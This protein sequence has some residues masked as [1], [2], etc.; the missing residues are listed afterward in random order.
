M[1]VS[2]RWWIARRRAPVRAGWS[3]TAAAR[4]PTERGRRARWA[5]IACRRREGVPQLPPRM[6][7]SGSTSAISAATTPE[8][9]RAS[10]WRTA[11]WSSRTRR[12]RPTSMAVDARS[13]QAQLG[14]DLGER[15]GPAVRAG[16]DEVGDLA[17]E[18][19]VPA[20]HLAVADDCAAQALA[21]VEV[22]E[23]VEGAVAGFAFG[24]GGPVH[25]VVDY[26]RPVDERREDVG[27]GELADQ[28]RRVG[29]VDE[30]PGGAVDGIG[31]ADHGEPDRGPASA[32]TDGRG[33]QGRGDRAPGRRAGEPPLGPRHRVALDVDRSRRRRPSGAML[34]GQRGARVGGQ[35][36]V[37]C[38]RARARWCVRRCR[39]S[40]P[41]S[42]SLR[43]ALRRRRLGDARSG[44]RSRRGSAGGGPSARAGRARRSATA[45]APATASRGHATIL[46]RSLA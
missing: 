45:A 33:A 12:R 43:D 38:R 25:V 36:V 8:M 44:R 32:R 10:P 6:T 29:Q 9:A 39:R 28:E 20:A 27:G 19:V 1:I 17:G 37:D 18:A 46:V 21:Q 41:A 26:D 14:E 23:I 4:S 31:G 22:G 42:A 35:R 11:S 24:A 13:A 2:R 15:H 16:G 40:S 34:D 3:S 30:P 7:T 5:S